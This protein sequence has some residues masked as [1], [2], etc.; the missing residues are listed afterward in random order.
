MILKENYYLPTYITLAVSKRF[1]G[2]IAKGKWLFMILGDFIFSVQVPESWKN[3][4]FSSKTA[5][6]GGGGAVTNIDS[7]R[8]GLLVNKG[9]LDS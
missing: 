6:G 9:F 2:N 3:L 1:G 4:A 7:S 8:N 5:S